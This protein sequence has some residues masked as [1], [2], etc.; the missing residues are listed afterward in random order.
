MFSPRF[1]PEPPK[2]TGI[3]DG[4]QW[5][6]DHN[7]GRSSDHDDVERTG[8]AL[9]QEISRRFQL[10]KKHPEWLVIWGLQI[11]F[12][13][14]EGPF[15]SH[16][17]VRVRNV[18]RAIMEALARK[19]LPKGWSWTIM[20]VIGRDPYLF[21]TSYDPYEAGE[22]FFVMGI[23][24]SEHPTFIIVRF[25]GG[26]SRLFPAD[27]APL[28]IERIGCHLDADYVNAISADYF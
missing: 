22:K 9:D 25:R 27:E 3:F 12:R 15:N 7:Q 4:F 18:D 28:I 26:N 23:E 5:A 16:Y 1:Y 11:E 19:Y 6:I 13:N 2:P 8:R 14:D 10:I 21:L 20:E 17:T 24:P